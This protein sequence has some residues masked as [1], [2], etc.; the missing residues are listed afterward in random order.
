MITVQ[1][2]IGLQGVVG[3]TRMFCGFVLLGYHVLI[4]LS[5]VC[6]HIPPLLR[7]KNDQQESI[8][9][10]VSLCG[11]HLLQKEWENYRKFHNQAHIS[12]ANPALSAWVTLHRNAFRKEARR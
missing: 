4:S 2:E 11:I 6:L 5:Y 12:L 8:V 7:S 10:Y 9:R 1:G 3:Q